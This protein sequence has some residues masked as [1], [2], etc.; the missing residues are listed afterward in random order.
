MRD[1]PGSW[2]PPDQA[3]VQLIDIQSVGDV[4]VGTVRRHR[5]GP[6]TPE[7]GV[8]VREGDP[9][10]DQIQRVGGR[11]RFR[12][13]IALLV[14]GTLFVAGAVLKPWP[15]GRAVPSQSPNVAATPAPLVAVATP[16]GYPDVPSHGW[17]G[18]DWSVLLGTDPHSSWGFATVAMP[19]FVA[20]AGDTTVPSPTTTWVAADSPSSPAVVHVAR[21]R[22]V[23][24]L[25]VTWPSSL[26][27]SSVTFVFLGGPEY[28]SYAPPPGFPPFTQV[29]P[30]PAEQVA[31]PSASPSVAPTAGAAIRS[32]EFWIPPSEASF[33]AASHSVPFAWRYLPWPW[34]N[35]TYRVT[36]TAQTGT[37]ELLLRV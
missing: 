17:G 23:F 35:G 7:P 36:L 26:M 9:D 31:S 24:A 11:R 33:A 5:H 14:A 27:V 18:V 8:S 2:S 37:T 3:D 34:P 15:A 22:S 28:E 6:V 20:V 21:D 4:S 13:E 1:D 12:P 30:L 10:Q 25:A 29:S 19:T 16:I 32:G